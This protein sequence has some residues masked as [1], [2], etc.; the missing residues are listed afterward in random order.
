M[1]LIYVVGGVFHD[2]CVWMSFMIHVTIHV[3]GGV[4]VKGGEELID[5]WL[6]GLVVGG[7][8]RAFI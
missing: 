2:S 7:R 6:D 3:V 4:S 5:R 8:G 1:F